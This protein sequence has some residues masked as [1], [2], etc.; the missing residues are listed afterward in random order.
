[1]TWAACD[2]VAMPV[3]NEKH[4]SIHQLI[5]MWCNKNAIHYE[6]NPT[7]SDTIFWDM[8][9]EWDREW[10]RMGYYEEKS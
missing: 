6:F 3:R 2:S 5:P 8:Q 10:G 7:G 9:R 1:M 4:S